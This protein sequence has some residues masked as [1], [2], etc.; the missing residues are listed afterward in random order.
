MTHRVLGCQ[1]KFRRPNAVSVLCWMSNHASKFP[2]SE[3]I[4]CLGIY[5]SARRGTRDAGGGHRHRVKLACDQCAHPCVPN[6]GRGL[7]HV[8]GPTRSKAVAGLRVWSHVILHDAREWTGI[9]VALVRSDGA[10]SWLLQ[11]MEAR[12]GLVLRDLLPRQWWVC[13]RR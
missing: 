7:Q 8:P 13:S 2:G 3:E 12:G 4:I 11:W 10:R 1:L 6:G 5:G 9:P